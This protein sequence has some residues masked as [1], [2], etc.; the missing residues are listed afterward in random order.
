MTTGLPY[1]ERRE[2]LEGLKLAGPNWQTPAYHA[3]DGAALLGAA[4]AQKLP[5]VIAKRLDSRYEVGK[6]SADWILVPAK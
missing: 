5:G 3:G 4:R 6:R 1:T 2:R